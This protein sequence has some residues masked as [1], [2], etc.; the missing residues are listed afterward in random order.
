MASER[1]Q[2]DFSYDQHC[3]ELKLARQ[4]LSRN[5]SGVK[6]DGR[7]LAMDHKTNPGPRT[8]V[9]KSCV[10][11][12]IREVRAK[13][14]QGGTVVFIFDRHKQMRTVAHL[15]PG[16]LEKEAFR[17]ALEAHLYFVGWAAKVVAPNDEDYRIVRAQLY[18]VFGWLKLFL[19][20]YDWEE[21]RP[22]YCPASY[23]W[24]VKEDSSRLHVDYDPSVPIPQ[25]PSSNGRRR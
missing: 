16:N 24:W 4:E 9:D 7:V 17:A 10:K 6:F 18:R 14:V 21:P 5:M 12:A 11:S 22:G 20:I 19:Q 23:E 1:E 13:N 25:N 15:D 3:S 8:V 2:A